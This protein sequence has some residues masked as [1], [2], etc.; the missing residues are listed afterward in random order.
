MRSRVVPQFTKREKEA[1]KEYVDRQVLDSLAKVQWMMIVCMNEELGLGEQRIL[2]VIDRYP[3]ML[4][5]YHGFQ[6]D[7]VGDEM[8]FRRM[9][10]IMP[11]TF[12]Q[13]YEHE[14]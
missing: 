9:K 4:K 6:K 7:D 14:R 12:T 10:Q 2:R 1:I 5:E 8:L 13:L 11:N 3:E